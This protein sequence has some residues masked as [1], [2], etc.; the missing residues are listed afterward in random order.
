ML[1]TLT[2]FAFIIFACQGRPPKYSGAISSD[3][4]TKLAT[5][6]D[7]E[8]HANLPKIEKLVRLSGRY[9]RNIQVLKMYGWR[10]VSDFLVKTNG[11]TLETVFTV[12]TA[13]KL[14]II[15][16]R[17]INSYDRGYLL[18]A[19]FSNDS[20]FVL[21]YYLPT[22]ELNSAEQVAS[23]Y[24]LRDTLINIGASAYVNILNKRRKQFQDSLLPY[25]YNTKLKSL[26]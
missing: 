21:K 9:E 4:L 7:A 8:M 20:L 25:F 3:S 24:Y 14:K 10:R 17:A 2:A 1:K 15:A 22:G 23:T 6:F 11:D 13:K 12:D 18:S 16:E 19:E 26:D 5:F